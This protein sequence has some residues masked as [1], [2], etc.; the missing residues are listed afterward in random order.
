MFLS[1]IIPAYNEEKHI[2]SSLIQVANFLTRQGYPY[3]IVVVDDGSRD[4]TYCIAKSFA[5]TNGNVLVL[6]NPRNEGKGAVVKNGVMTAQGE[7]ILFMDADYSTPI[8][9]V[10]NMLN[11]LALDNN[12]DFV[13]ASRMMEDSRVIKK[14]LP[15]RIVLGKLYH[16]IVASLFLRGI[17]DYNCGFKLYRKKIAKE[18]FNLIVTKNYTFDVELLY[19]ARKLGYR[20]KEMPVTWRHS[21]NSKVRPFVDGIKS[22]VSLARIKL[23]Y[24]KFPEK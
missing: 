9:E 5:E 3:E 23:R 6:K 11:L 2:L 24:T 13:I 7:Y 12:Y 16:Y 4:S 14:E 10:E 1:V 18:L 22:L 8:E 19:L 21:H 20:H 15:L 17:T